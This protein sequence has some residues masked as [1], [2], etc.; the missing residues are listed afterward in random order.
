M[1]AMKLNRINLRELNQLVLTCSECGTH[2]VVE[3][4][5]VK[6]DI[7]ACPACNYFYP[8]AAVEAVK[9][10]RKAQILIKGDDKAKIEFDVITDG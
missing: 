2:V 3:S 4:S 1:V 9:L 10:L 7:T 5:L 6:R 8:E